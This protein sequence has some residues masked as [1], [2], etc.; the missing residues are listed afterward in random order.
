MPSVVVFLK[1]YY[2][3]NRLNSLFFLLTGTVQCVSCKIYLLSLGVEIWF[4]IL[5]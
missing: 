3:C 4:A 5:K 2:L 1:N